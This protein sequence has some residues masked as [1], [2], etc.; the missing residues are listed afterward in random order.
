MKYVK[1]CN[2]ELLNNNN[3]DHRNKLTKNGNNSSTNVSFHCIIKNYNVNGNEI[4]S[5]HLECTFV[6]LDL[7]FEYLNSL[8]KCLN[9]SINN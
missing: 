5:G 4:I 3:F 8:V 9:F 6:K 1:L 2:H 7:I